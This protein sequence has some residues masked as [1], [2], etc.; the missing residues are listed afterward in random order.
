VSIA[1]CRGPRSH[2]SGRINFTA[3][4]WWRSAFSSVGTCNAKVIGTVSILLE[5]CS[6]MGQV[7]AMVGFFNQDL[8]QEH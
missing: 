4:R 2:L 7:E 1:L 8:L 3:W 6:I 5:S